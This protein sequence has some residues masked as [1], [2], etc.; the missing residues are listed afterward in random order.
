[1]ERRDAFCAQGG[2]RVIGDLLAV[3]A[4]GDRPRRQRRRGGQKC[5]RGPTAGASAWAACA[6]EIKNSKNRGVLL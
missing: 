3:G 1:M 5:K 2:L 6:N 4:E